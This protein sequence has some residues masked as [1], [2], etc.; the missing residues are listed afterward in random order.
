MDEANKDEKVVVF[1]E[2]YLPMFEGPY[3]ERHF[4][5]F[6]WLAPRGR[7]RPMRENHKDVDLRIL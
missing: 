7:I 1:K 4:S 2:N 6:V 3:S 5:S